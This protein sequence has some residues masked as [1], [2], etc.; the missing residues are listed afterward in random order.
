MKVKKGRIL[1]IKEKSP[2]N[3]KTIKNRKK[4]FPEFRKTLERKRYFFKIDPR[5]VN[6]KKYISFCLK[7]IRMFLNRNEYKPF[8]SHKIFFPLKNKDF[9]QVIYFLTKKL[10]KNFKT[11]NKPEEN[12]PK[13][14]KIIGYPVS[15]TKTTLLCTNSFPQSSVLLNCL[16][17]M[18]ELCLYDLK[19]TFENE[20]ITKNSLKKNLFWNQLVKNYKKYL[21]EKKNNDIF[22]KIIKLTLL[23]EINRRKK[24]K[25]M[26][27]RF[28]KKINSRNYFF[29]VVV[30]LMFFFEEKVKIIS[31]GKNSFLNQK[32][33][34]EINGYRFVNRMKNKLKKS[35]EINLTKKKPFSSKFEFKKSTFLKILKIF[36]KINYNNTHF[37]LFLTT[38]SIQILR[39]LIYWGEIFF[40]PRISIKL[41]RKNY[42]QNFYLK[43]FKNFIQKN[44]QLRTKFFF[45]LKEFKIFFKIQITFQ[46]KVQKT[47]KFLEKIDILYIRNRQ[48]RLN[49]DII[50]HIW[51]FKNCSLEKFKYEK[52]EKIQEKNLIIDQTSKKAKKEIFI[53]IFRQIYKSFHYTRLIFLKFI[54][55]INENITYY[56]N[57]LIFIKK[58]LSKKE[59]IINWSRIKLIS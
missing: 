1:P 7:E 38:L 59:K 25:D 45:S 55:R 27:I 5:P 41:I 12:V 51:N 26:K 22:P 54:E 2:E 19:T 20:I 9:F 37:R 29:M 8:K 4:N 50:F 13:I 40:Y 52:I 44:Y 48:N 46:N 17:W 16:Y 58:N 35:E 49:F 15:I 23:N 6:D 47:S 18:V 30:Y 53:Q 14:L 36:L 32:I 33:K 3:S 34:L 10:D 11:E 21:S 42:L 57:D 56:I 43:L 24:C 28:A 39:N 31:E